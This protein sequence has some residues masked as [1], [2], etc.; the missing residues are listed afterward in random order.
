MM[1]RAVCDIGLK[2][3]L[4]GLLHLNRGVVVFPGRQ[5]F[6]KLC[7]ELIKG[8]QSLSQEG[9]GGGGEVQ[10]ERLELSPP[11]EQEQLLPCNGGDGSWTWRFVACVSIP[12]NPVSFPILSIF[13][14]IQSVLLNFNLNLLILKRARIPVWSATNVFTWLFPNYWS[15]PQWSI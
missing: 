5:W 14:S 6:S 4:K 2:V 15:A 13:Y 7:C 11:G 12:F 1:L 8:G 10:E 9:V 3:C